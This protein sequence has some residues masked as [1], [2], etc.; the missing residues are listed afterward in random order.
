MLFSGKI[1]CEINFENSQHTFEIEKYKTIRDLYNLFLESF[2]NIKYPLM[3]RLNTNKYP[4]EG[5]DLDTRLLPFIKEEDQ[6]L[7]F[8]ITKKYKCL[9]CSALNK[10]NENNYISKY[11]LT[12][13]K[14]VCNECTKKYGSAHNNHNLININPTDL[15]NS[16][17][18][19]C[20][21]LIADLSEQIISF[22]IQNEFMNK[23]DFMIKMELWKNN[24]IEKL[25]RFEILIKN[26]FEKLQNLNFFYKNKENICNKIMQNLIKAERE[27]NEE[28][29]LEGEKKINNFTLSEAEDQI[30]KLKKNFEEI[31][32]VKKEINPI[33]EYNNIKI[34]EK[35]MNNINISFDQLTESIFLIEDNI[36]NYEKL[37]NLDDLGKIYKYPDFFNYQKNNK[38]YIDSIS[39]IIKSKKRNNFLKS[40][41]I[42]EIQN[43][44][45]IINNEINNKKNNI[46]NSKEGGKLITQISKLNDIPASYSIVEYSKYIKNNEEKTK[47]SIN[48]NNGDINSNNI[49]ILKVAENRKNIVN[50]MNISNEREKYLTLP[51]IQNEDKNNKKFKNNIIKNE[52]NNLFRSMDNRLKRNKKK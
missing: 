50:E 18:L 39:K 29:F 45:Y 7:I 4:F 5:K 13:N 24:I 42:P 44:R 27:M 41:K 2:P 12:C 9:S 8:E 23:E 49:K 33:I 25:N 32:K 21:N 38:L 34:M 52:S 31:E 1:K 6:K 16:V 43:K 14:Y 47:S 28:L 46:N 20:I 11:C 3:I 19:W 30:Q 10:N 51:K 22:R 35:N 48:L 40:N 26:I 37:N 15:K 17:K 36:N